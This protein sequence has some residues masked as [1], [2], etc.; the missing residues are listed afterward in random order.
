MPINM[1]YRKAQTMSSWHDVFLMKLGK[2]VD[3]AKSVNV[4]ASDFFED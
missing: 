3:I 4:I 1:S 2:V